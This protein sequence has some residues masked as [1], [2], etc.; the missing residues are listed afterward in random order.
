[1]AS[2]DRENYDLFFYKHHFFDYEDEFRIVLFR[3]GPVTIP[4]PIDVIE[5][6]TLSPVGPPSPEVLSRLQLRFEDKL[7]E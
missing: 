2:T 4:V 3:T 7:R 1:M 6:V 5:S